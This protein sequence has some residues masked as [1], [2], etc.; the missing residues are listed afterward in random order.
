M[1]AV[2][3]VPPEELKARTRQFATAFSINA[4]KRFPTTRLHQAWIKAGFLGPEATLLC[5]TIA[6]PACNRERPAL[7]RFWLDLRPQP[8]V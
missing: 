7:H 1:A 3:T 6:N 5:V 8:L 4:C 2:Q